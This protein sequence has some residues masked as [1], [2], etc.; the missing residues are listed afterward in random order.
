MNRYNNFNK[1]NQDR[2]QNKTPTIKDISKDMYLSMFAMRVYFMEFALD[3]QLKTE[4]NF[5]GSDIAKCKELFH[6]KGLIHTGT[7]ST[8]NEL[9]RECIYL[10]NPHIERIDNLNP[11]TYRRTLTFK[12]LFESTLRDEILTNFKD[13]ETIMIYYKTLQS[14]YKSYE[15]IKHQKIKEEKE[16]DYREVKNP[17]G[18]SYLKPTI[19]KRQTEL[20]YFEVRAEYLLSN[21][22]RAETEKDKLMLQIQQE[23][24]SD[25]KLLSNGSNTDLVLYNQ[26]EQGIIQ[27][28]HTKF[29]DMKKQLAFNNRSKTINISEVNNDIKT[30]KN[31]KLNDS[32][33][34]GLDKE[35]Y[36]ITKDKC[37]D[38]KDLNKQEINKSAKDIFMEEQEDVYQV[39]GDMIATVEKV[40]K[41]EVMIEDKNKNYLIK[42]MKQGN[43]KQRKSARVS[44]ENLYG[45]LE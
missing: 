20:L 13:N 41:I 35:S 12:K 21:P 33:E 40:K 43:D 17:N 42:Q 39:F 3:W 15:F 25:L 45:V 38:I 9:F 22:H 24:V 37:K 10:S 7:Y 44:Y 1:Y 2:Q 5:K 8:L 23:K 4:D 36:I 6:T 26:E 14:K 28:Y 34:F 30:I 18:T 32:S 16:L 19:K 29:I 31:N 11:I 27:E